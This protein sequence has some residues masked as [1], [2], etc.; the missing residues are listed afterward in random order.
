MILEHLVPQ[1]F[2]SR[3]IAMTLIAG[4]V[5]TGIFIILVQTA[6]TR[7]PAAT[8]QAI[9]IGEQQQWQRSEKSCGSWLKISFGRRPK[10]WPFSGSLPSTELDRN[11]APTRC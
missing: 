6:A 5:P 10:M 7:F 8:R 2:S 3:L 11:A 4:L 9:T 1:R